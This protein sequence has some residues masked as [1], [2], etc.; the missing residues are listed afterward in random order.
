MAALKMHCTYKKGWLTFRGKAQIHSTYICIRDSVFDADKRLLPGYCFWFDKQVSACRDKRRA[1]SC[2]W[3]ITKA[4]TPC[5]FQDLQRL[6]SCFLKSCSYSQFNNLSK[7]YE[8]SVE[9]CLKQSP[10]AVLATGD[11]K[12]IHKTQIDFSSRSAVHICTTMGLI[13]A[14]PTA[15]WLQPLQLSDQLHF[16]YRTCKI[17]GETN[18]VLK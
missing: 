5:C 15:E 10:L 14:V 2:R 17:Q 13:K 18:V 11:L 9:I 12:N 16:V 8:A 6:R 7:T 4:L 1:V 3:V